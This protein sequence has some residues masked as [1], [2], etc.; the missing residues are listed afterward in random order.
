MS[1]A[2]R[3]AQQASLIVDARPFDRAGEL[4]AAA[5]RTVLAET[6][7]VRLAIPGGSALEAARQAQQRLAEAW[8]RVALTWVDERCVVLADEASNRGEAVRLGLLTLGDERE[9]G[10]ALELPLY[11]DGET[12][13]AALRRVRVSWRDDFEEELDV[14]L[15]G[16][17][18]DGH[19]ASLFPSLHV[20][21]ADESAYHVADSP[22]PPANR[23]TLSRA[24]LATARHVILVAAGEAKRDAV[25]R[26]MSGDPEL[27]AQGLEGLV[28]VTDVEPE[29]RA[30]A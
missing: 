23:I 28:V 4:L 12:P 21:L 27:P 5:L 10:P 30:R 14:V 13:E 9:A 19:V 18:A 16:M 29:E 1:R 3:S 2:E 8:R 24:A 11:L 20:T 15:L 17:G 26:L 25:Q 22:K 7:R 6:D